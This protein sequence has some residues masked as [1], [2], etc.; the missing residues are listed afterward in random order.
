MLM[1]PDVDNDG[2]LST[3]D[4]LLVINE[5]NA[6][7]QFGGAE[8]EG[9]FTSEDQAEG[10]FAPASI[11][12]AEPLLVTA[13]DAGTPI[14]ESTALPA[15]SSDQQSDD[16]LVDFATFAVPVKDVSSAATVEKATDAEKAVDEELFDVIDDIAGDV[17]EQWYDD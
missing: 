9:E 5:L 3:L 17:S 13:F 14:D 4:A 2:F 15:D 6:A 7:A 10:E 12:N 16:E 1:F 11:V 8:A